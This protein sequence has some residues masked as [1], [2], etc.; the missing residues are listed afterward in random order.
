MNG[1][2]LLSSLGFCVIAQAARP[3]TGSPIVQGSV[4]AAAM[5]IVGK[6]AVD[7]IKSAREAIQ[8]RN[9][10]AEAPAGQAQRCIEHVAKLASLEARLRAIELRIDHFQVQTISDVEPRLRAIEHRMETL[11]TKSK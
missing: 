10:S 1:T 4:V 9:G 3:E 6:V 2:L 5:V 7:A 11:A 8:R